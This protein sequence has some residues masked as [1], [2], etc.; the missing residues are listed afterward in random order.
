MIRISDRLKVRCM[1]H[2]SQL[3]YYIFYFLFSFFLLEFCLSWSVISMIL[4]QNVILPVLSLH[5]NTTGFFDPD[6]PW[7]GERWII[8]HLLAPTPPGKDWMHCIFSSQKFLI[9]FEIKYFEINKDFPLTWNG[10]RLEIEN[11]GFRSNNSYPTD[12]N[13]DSRTVLKLTL[14]WNKHSIK[15]YYCNIET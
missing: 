8:M 4:V 12:E 3:S 14:D 5:V 7:L 2:V 11:V 15:R 9:I 6:I 13:N 10:D 1:S